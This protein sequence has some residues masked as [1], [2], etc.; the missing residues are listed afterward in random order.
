MTI[1]QFST[2]RIYFTKDQLSI[3]SK[4]QILIRAAF[5][6]LQQKVT[7]VSLA[8]SVTKVSIFTSFKY[9]LQAFNNILNG[10]TSNANANASLL[11]TEQTS[12]LVQVIVN[13]TTL[14]QSL[15]KI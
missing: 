10:I 7:E 14:L 5:V 12:Q 2:V 9:R 3:I 4:A 6:S 13:V 8:I 1:V 11:T 15:G